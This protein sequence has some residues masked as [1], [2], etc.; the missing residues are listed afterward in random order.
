MSKTCETLL[1]KQG[2]AHKWCTPVDPLPDEQEQDDQLEP[3]YNSSVLIQDV[4]WKTC[5]E[6]WTIGTRG[7]WGSG[8]PV[9]AACH[10]DDDDIFFRAPGLKPYNDLQFSVIQRTLVLSLLKVGTLKGSIAPGLSR[11]WSNVNEEVLHIFQNF[12][13]RTLQSDAV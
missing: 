7:R 6:R 4:A 9:L 13:I 10:D 5:R 2:R 1:E 8:K 11:P 3:I 12:R